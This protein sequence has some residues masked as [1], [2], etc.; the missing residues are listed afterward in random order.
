MHISKLISY[1]LSSSYSTQYLEGLRRYKEQRDGFHILFVYSDNRVKKLIYHLKRYRD[2]KLSN[3]LAQHFYQAVSKLINHTDKVLVIPVPVSE[4]TAKKRGFNQCYDIAYY[5]SKNRPN[6]I[7]ADTFVDKKETCKQSTLSKAKR[8]ENIRDAFILK[9]PL[10]YH[11]TI[12]LVDDV[13]TT[14]CTLHELKRLVSRRDNKVV[15]LA[16]AS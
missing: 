10:P 3:L 16:V 2:L 5:I 13:L 15:C 9:K 1:L 4:N 6:W 8:K 14:G 12:L 7:L 11:H